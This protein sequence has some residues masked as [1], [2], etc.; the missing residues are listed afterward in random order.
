MPADLPTDIQA[1]EAAAW[2]DFV[3]RLGRLLAA[4]WPAMQ[5]RLG[6]RHEAFV[7]A[8]LAQAEKRGFSH[9]A[10]VARY[11]NLWFVWGPAFHDKPGFE[12]ALGLLAAPREREWVTVHQLVQRSL[13][14]LERRPEPRVQPAA[15]L[16]AD[17]RL[18]DQFGRMGRQGSL[19]LPPAAALPRK[20]CDVDAAE[21]RLT[22]EPWLQEYRLA[23]DDWQRITLP[24]PAAL[25]VDAVRPL[26]KLIGVLSSLRG[27]G[28]Q[29]Q[30]Q[31]RIKPHAVCHGDVHPGIDFSG[32]HGRWR[33]VGHETRSTS[34]PVATLEQPEVRTGPGTVVAEETS[35][36]IFSLELPTCGLRDEGEPIGSLKT[37]V[38]AWP[39]AQWWVEVQR[40]APTAQALQPGGRAWA[41]GVTR[42]RVER[43]GASL[44]SAPLRLQ[45]EDGLDGAI[46]D[47]LKAL[48]E[49]W[50]P[51]PGLA[52]PSLDVTLG[53]LT[54]KAACTWGWRAAPAGL[55]GRALM[56]LIAHLDMSACQADIQLGG[57]LELAGTRSRLRLHVAGQ[58]ALRQRLAREAPEPPLADVMLPA[59]VSFRFPFLIDIEPLATEQGCLLQLAGPVTGALVGEA[60]W[61]PNTAG[62]TGWEWFAGLRV[63]PVLLPLCI[64]DPLLGSSTLVLPL[65]PAL[66]L[67]DWSLA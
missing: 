11:V 4:T 20:A 48:A 6:D 66:T 53:V 63:E 8:A 23:G 27:Q 31:L 41:R 7:D 33:W 51:V 54:G 26:P 5:E 25:R 9:A 21:L 28:P 14:E 37:A 18:L 2:R 60:G 61:R 45:F 47:G 38:W 57:E 56:R 13:A 39:A 44:D 30:L 59:A 29:A 64:T 50:L 34:W 32:T 43:D 65:L 10:G 42:C 17:E 19:L 24:M 62:G 22:G 36:D 67:L 1:R 46:A 16:A 40:A 12:W 15:L 55:D 49:A 35:P 58:A 3:Q 52:S